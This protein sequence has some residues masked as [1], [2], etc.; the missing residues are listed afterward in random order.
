M[1]M[2]SEFKDFAMKGNLVDMSVA[3]VM[4]AA[5]NKVS[6]S[7]IDGIV[8]PPISLLTGGDLEGSIVLK[9]GVDAVM[10]NGKELAAAVPEIA[11]KYGAFLSS[12]I[13]FIVVA[14]VMFLIVRAINNM[15]KAE[16]APA[17]DGPSASESLLGE[18]RDLLKK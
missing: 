12:T 16:P 4:G 14:F 13:N 3:F 8:M 9:K 10:E 2:F 5:F 7:F 1:G 15:K 18:I 17:P 11:I 6:S